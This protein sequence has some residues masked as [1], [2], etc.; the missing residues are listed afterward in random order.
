L[1]GEPKISRNHA[2]RISL[3]ATKIAG[4]VGLDSGSVEDI[5]TAALL[6][7]MFNMKEMGITNEVL[8]KAAQ[9]SQEEL[10][11]A[12]QNRARRSRNSAP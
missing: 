2:C 6:F 10:Q 8:C 12:M 11:P 7:N 4:A 1:S 9:L 5:R 3:C